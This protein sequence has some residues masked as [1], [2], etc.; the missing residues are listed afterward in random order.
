[1]VAALKAL[2]L[3]VLKA[4]TSRVVIKKYGITVFRKKLPA[5]VVYWVKGTIGLSAFYVSIRYAPYK[6]PSWLRTIN[7]L[8]GRQSEHRYELIWEKLNAEEIE[9]NMRKRLEEAMA[10]KK[11]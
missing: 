3:A 8:S 1:M 5:K 6:N 2:A 4:L 7:L 9:K 10:S 11:E